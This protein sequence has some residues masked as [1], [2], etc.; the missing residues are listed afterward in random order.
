[1]CMTLALARAAA[2][3]SGF[4]QNFYVA[5]ATLIPVLFIALAVEG[6]FIRALLS[7]SSWATDTVGQFVLA[8]AVYALLKAFGVI[9]PKAVPAKSPPRRPPGRLRRMWR[10]IVN[11][12]EGRG[13]QVAIVAAI[14]IALIPAVLAVCIVVLGTVAEIAAVVALYDMHANSWTGPFVLATLIF[15]I[16]VIALPP[17]AILARAGYEA[18]HEELKTTSSGTE[19]TKQASAPAAATDTQ[20][21]GTS[22]AAAPLPEPG[23]EPP[24]PTAE[25]V[26]PARTGQTGSRAEGEKPTETDTGPV[27]TAGG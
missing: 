3:G 22:Q 17:A 2:E 18:V 23:P 11:G 9:K 4:N 27:S 26:A 14:A 16:I 1:M 15:L 21:T 13:I 8:F 25:R 12:L 24:Q 6:R 19:T 10:W 5:A 20:S 7:A